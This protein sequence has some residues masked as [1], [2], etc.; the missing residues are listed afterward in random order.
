M[1]MRR[2]AIDPDAR[3]GSM[4]KMLTPEVLAAGG[5]EHAHQTAI[6]QWTVIN[7]SNFPDID[8]LH[9]IPNGGARSVS[10]AAS[11]KAEGVKS[12]VPDLCLPVPLGV[13]AGLY[14]ELKVPKHFGTKNGG[15]SDNQI[16]WQ[17]RLRTK[18][19]AVVTAYGWEAAVRAI[20]DYYMLVLV[21]P[22]DDDCAMYG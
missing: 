7:G 12:G 6:M 11:L 21:M 2:G 16:K 20:Q 1:A 13:F 3:V 8:L 19:Y 4:G 14:L 22:N 15:R 9:A 5:S 10:V 17:K 18:H